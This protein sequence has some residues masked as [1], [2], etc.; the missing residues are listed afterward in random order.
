M[1]KKAIVRSLLFDSY[2]KVQ[3]TNI[4]FSR[5]NSYDHPLKITADFTIP[6]YA[7]VFGEG[8]RFRPMVVGYLMNNPLNNKQRDLPVTL[9]A[10]E[11]LKLTYSITLPEG[12]TLT[13][14][15]KDRT[16][17]FPG[18]SLSEQYDIEGNTLNYRFYININKKQFSEEWYP[19]LLNL[20]QRW[21]QLSRTRWFAN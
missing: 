15:L 1:S 11:H 19:Q 2:P 12:Y 5:L 18:A 4:V 21:V 16:L 6:D 9:D 8:I 17:K 14:Q 7:T 3:L 13:G 10:P 20:Y